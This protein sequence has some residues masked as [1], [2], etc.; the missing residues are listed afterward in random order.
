MGCGSSAPSQ[1]ESTEGGTLGVM[2]KR[3]D[4]EK[5]GYISLKNLEEMMKDDKD[6]FQG[7]DA[8]HI[9]NKYGTNG[10]MN[11]EQFKAWWNSTYTTYNE[12]DIANLVNEVENE[13]HMDTIEEGELPL[14]GDQH[15]TNKAVGRS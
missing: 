5:K 14:P 9:M 3:F 6:H 15:I 11:F 4:K 7:R 1:V 2:F 12:G 8:G 13:Q 10:K